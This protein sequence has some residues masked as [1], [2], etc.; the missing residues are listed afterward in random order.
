M[1][2]IKS[3]KIDLK[4][5]KEGE[6]TFEYQLADEYFKAIEAP[7]IQRGNLSCHV[8]VRRS[9]DFFELNFHTKGFVHIP[10]D[11][12]LDDMEQA[13]E[14][15]NRLI[16]KFGENYSEEDELVTVAEDEG[17][18]DV[19]WFIYEFIVLNIPIRHVHAP[20]KCNSAM[21]D[22]LNHFSPLDEEPSAARS[23]E[24]NDEQTMDPRWA[25]LSN[26]K[27]ED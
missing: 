2:S 5:L 13:I 18:L 15:D 26:L 6:N 11:V 27:I 8:S 12:C 21:I 22:V 23:G 16:A 14:T 20:G 24:D 7:E 1:C 3:F 25:A 17:I 4:A 19:A 9:E 10:C